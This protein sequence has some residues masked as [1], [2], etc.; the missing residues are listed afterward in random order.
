MP[1]QGDAAPARPTYTNITHLVSGGGGVVY[2]AHHEGFD[3]PC[4]QKLVP[5]A[6]MPAAIAFAEPRLLDQLAHP[7]LVPVLDTQPDPNNPTHVVFTMP[8]Y[9]Q[10]TIRFALDQKY[11][12]SIQQGIDIGCDL[13]TALGHLHA[14]GLVHRDVKP[15]N[16]FLADNL[17]QGL[18]GDLG[19]AAQLE[20]D[21]KA[22]GGPGTFLFMPPEA[23]G[24]GSRVGPEMDV[25]CAGLTIFEMVNGPI[26]YASLAGAPAFGR[27]ARGLRGIPDSALEFSSHIP[28]ELRRVI[29][30]AIKASTAE[31]YPTARAFI[32]ALRRL[33]LVDWREVARGKDL[34]G[35]W[36]GSWPPRL[37]VRKRR[38][39]RV[40]VTRVRRGL[41]AAPLQRTAP[42]GPWRH[43][44]IADA[45]I[46]PT[47]SKALAHFFS[48]INIKAAQL[49]PA[50]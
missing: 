25:Y 9:R 16:V 35:I 36:E 46:G 38:Q 39:Y 33:T 15:D 6:H 50:S 3:K 12:F 14:N 8:Y 4:V 19:I 27:L 48:A 47:D 30:K 32:Q 13:L 29:R 42:G 18:L 43:F 31:R 41:S 1:L 26:D 45:S 37:A 20:A 7:N 44:G 23:F 2:R 22:P 21:G 28:P 34:E 11:R 40:E 5:T 17:R 24:P 49:R 10:G